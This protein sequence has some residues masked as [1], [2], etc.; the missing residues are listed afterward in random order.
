MLPVFPST[1]RTTIVGWLDLR[2]HP[3]VIDVAVLVESAS[4]PSTVTDRTLVGISSVSCPVTVSF[5]VS[6]S[7][8]RYG[9]PSVDTNVNV[10]G[11]AVTVPCTSTHAAIAYFLVRPLKLTSNSALSTFD[12][13]VDASNTSSTFPFAIV[14]AA[15]TVCPASYV[16]LAFETLA[17]AGV[18]SLGSKTTFLFVAFATVAFAPP[19]STTIPNVAG[20]LIPLETATGT[21]AY[22]FFHICGLS[23][24]TFEKVC[25]AP[26][27]AASVAWNGVAAPTAPTLL[28][29]MSVAW[30]VT[31]VPIGARRSFTSVSAVARAATSSPSTRTHDGT[32]A[33]SLPAIVTVVNELPIF[34]SNA[35]SPYPFVVCVTHTRSADFRSTAVTVVVATDVALCTTVGATV[36]QS[37]PCAGNATGTTHGMPRTSPSA[38]ASSVT[39]RWYASTRTELV[40]AL[41]VPT[42]PDSARTRTPNTTLSAP[43]GTSPKL[44][45]TFASLTKLGV[46]STVC[47]GAPPPIV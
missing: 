7:L 42:S 11:Q 36:V 47:A 10:V 33:I 27:P 24:V 23:R 4:S 13:S 14:A 8:T 44:A 22:S 34:T 25:G 19:P 26:L 31:S 18:G 46:A 35:K 39:S 3:N 17:P 15:A 28:A 41:V 45:T 40:S 37:T 38:D 30:N 12:P 1:N 5:T 16:N 6:W 9:V 32:S 20:K 29:V 2:A 21:E 43:A